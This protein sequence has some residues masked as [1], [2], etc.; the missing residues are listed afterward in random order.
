MN[1]KDFGQ[2]LALAAVKG[3]DDREALEIRDHLREC[4]E[5]AERWKQYQG[6]VTGHFDAATEIQAMPIHWRASAG[7]VMESSVPPSRVGPVWRWV[8]PMAGV[9]TAAIALFLWREPMRAPLVQRPLTG[10]TARAPGT[11]VPAPSM[12]A[13]RNAIEKLGDS[14]LDALLARDA[15][16]LLPKTEDRVMR[17]E[18][19]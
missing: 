15:Q 2:G 8:F 7:R 17:D 18:L 9:A 10:V 11:E 1:C 6:V 3:L 14:S 13:Y 5:C 19:F 12:A 16:R 4:G